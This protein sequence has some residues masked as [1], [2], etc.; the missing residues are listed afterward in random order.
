MNNQTVDEQSVVARW[1]QHWWVIALRGLLALLFGLGALIWPGLTLDVL[2]ALFGAYA[3][4]DGICALILAGLGGE[5]KAERGWLLLEG[6]IG[7]AVGLITFAWPGVTELAL[8]Y[9]IATHAIIIGVMHIVAAIQLRKEIE[10]EWRL[11][12]NGILALLCGI[13]LVLYPGAGALALITVIGVYA[14]LAGLLLIGLGWRVWGLQDEVAQPA[15]KT[16]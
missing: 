5:Y 2:T 15:A 8:L 4:I 7:L 12:L 9:L 13:G 11:V 1:A 3:L 16:A 14:I 6:V 10:G